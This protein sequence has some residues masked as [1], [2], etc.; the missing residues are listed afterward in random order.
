M[1]LAEIERLTK[2]YAAASEALEAGQ[3]E[4]EAEVAAVWTPRLP[5]LRRRA[6][7]VVEARA[8]LEA[9]IDGNRGLFAKPRTRLFHGVKV[10][11]QKARG[12]ISWADADKVCALIRKHLPEQ[13]EVLI[14]SVEAP[15]KEALNGV[16][17]ADLRKI[18][19]TVTEDG[20][21]VLIK[22]AASDVDR[23]A[24]ALLQGKEGQS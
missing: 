15:V 19:V 2:A 8:A 11:L 22:P 24:E 21:R 16:A 10:G 20:D 5:V 7:A 3:R 4:L 14:R 9:A 17:V 12:K 6:K 1:S 18:G 23:L 13:V